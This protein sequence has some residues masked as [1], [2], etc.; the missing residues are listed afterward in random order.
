M[1]KLLRI[2]ITLTAVG[3][4]AAS[5]QAQPAPKIL[6]IDM[7][8]ALDSYYKYQDSKNKLNEATQKAQDQV[9]EYKKEMKAI[10]DQ[11]GEKM[12]QSKNSVLKQ[13]VRDQAAADA[14]KMVGEFQQRQQALQQFAENTRASLQQRMKIATDL[15]LEDIKNAS[16]SLAR[17]RGATIVLDKGG[18]SLL[19]VPSVVY[20]DA[21]YDI[22]DDVL[23]ELNKDRPVTTTAAPAATPAPAASTPATFSVPNVTAPAKPADK[24]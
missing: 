2:L 24:K 23:K 20:A 21:S 12:E 8:K 10:Q 13:E 11:Y 4:L 7:A 1:N 17:A 16:A 6:V 3:G 19:G 22:T 14:Q 18:P 15:L 5:L 9:D